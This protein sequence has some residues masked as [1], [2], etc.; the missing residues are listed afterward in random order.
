MWENTHER[1]AVS[2]AQRRITT[3]VSQA[4]VNTTTRNTPLSL[5]PPVQSSLIFAYQRE[6]ENVYYAFA[7]VPL[8]SLVLNGCTFE[9][10]IPLPVDASFR[11]EYPSGPLDLTDG[12]YEGHKPRR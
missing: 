8:L 5:I 4:V 2:S 3:Q 12:T 11:V 1:L 6:T 9:V 10:T 7:S